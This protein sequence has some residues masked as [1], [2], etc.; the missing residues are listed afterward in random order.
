MDNSVQNVS[1]V[2]TTGTFCLSLFDHEGTS[3]CLDQINEIGTFTVEEPNQN[4]DCE[5]FRNIRENCF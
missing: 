4:E 3:G 1:V 2:Y 5:A